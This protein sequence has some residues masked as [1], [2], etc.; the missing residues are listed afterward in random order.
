MAAG[1]D[2]SPLPA[3]R[4]LGIRVLGWP[5]NQSVRHG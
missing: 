3:H 5:L 1:H 2:A 4:R